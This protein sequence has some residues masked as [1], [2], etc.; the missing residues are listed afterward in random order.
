M[1]SQEIHQYDFANKI[2][3]KVI[4]FLVGPTNTCLKDKYVRAKNR[5]L[6]NLGWLLLF[7]A[8]FKKKKDYPYIKGIFSNPLRTRAKTSTSKN[9]LCCQ[10]K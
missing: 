1:I 6:G 9:N 4:C 10:T 8:F 3:I 7:H 5:R 2:F